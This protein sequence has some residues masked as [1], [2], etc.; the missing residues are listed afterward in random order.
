MCANGI[1]EENRAMEQETG[2]S[3]KLHL[4]KYVHLLMLLDN[5]ELTVDAFEKAFLHLRRTD[6][7]LLSGLFS[8]SVSRILGTLFLDVTDYAPDHL[9]DPTDPFDISSSELVN[10]AHS[11]LELLR[12]YVR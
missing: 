6:T 9:F 4:Q 5:K 7:Y 12:P 3:D 8:D 2:L 10:R 1:G 11:A